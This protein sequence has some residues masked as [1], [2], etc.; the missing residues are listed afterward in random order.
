MLKSKRV[1]RLTD[2]ES[3]PLNPAYPA[4]LP[5]RNDRE[6]VERAK[7]D[8]DAAEAML[9]LRVNIWRLDSVVK[10]KKRLYLAICD[11]FCEGRE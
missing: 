11:S 10:S 3:L 9:K 8:L 4:M 1:N 7:T 5:I 2:R 6:A